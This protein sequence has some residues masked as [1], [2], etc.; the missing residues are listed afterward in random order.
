L[1]ELT[2]TTQKSN[3]TKVEGVVGAPKTGTQGMAHHTAP[4]YDTLANIGLGDGSTR[5][6]RAQRA[7]DERAKNKALHDKSR[8]D[9]R[10]RLHIF[11]PFKI[12]K[13]VLA[14]YQQSCDPSIAANN[15]TF[16]QASLSPDQRVKLRTDQKWQAFTAKIFDKAIESLESPNEKSRYGS[17]TQLHREGLLLIKSIAGRRQ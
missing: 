9:S 16:G 7:A 8:L 2:T 3:V 12:S 17:W 10:E 5:V 15:L 4:Y 14:A 6:S 13:Q 1:T 11:G